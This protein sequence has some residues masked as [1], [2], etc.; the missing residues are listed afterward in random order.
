MP[1]F[2]LVLLALPS[3]YAADAPQKLAPAPGKVAAPAS[4][5]VEVDNEVVDRRTCKNGDDERLLQVIPK[6]KGCTLH[7]TK[8][9][10]TEIKAHATHGVEVCTSALG[11]IQATLEKA[12]F[13][14]E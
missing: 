11:R 2:V 8:F 5:A 12:G 1:W 3:A 9:G 6:L 4:P 14:C 13:R 10:K 7:Y